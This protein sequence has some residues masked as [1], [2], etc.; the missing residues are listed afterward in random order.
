MLR[1]A[2]LLVA[3]FAYST[4]EAQLLSTVIQNA[5]IVTMSGSTLEK[6]T[7]ILKGDRIAAIGV[8]PD[9]PFLSRRIDAQGGTVT[10]GLI[11]VHS[12]L[13]MTSGSARSGSPTARAVDAFDRYAAEHLEE[14]LRNG[15]TTV[16]ISS[17]GAVGI[18]GTGAVVRLVPDTSGTLGQPMNDVSWLEIDLGSA[19]S[20]LARV[21]TFDSVRK[22]L[23]DA[24]QYRR[25][26]EIY[27]ED[28]EEYEEKLKERGARKKKADE[29]KKGKETASDK[30]K[31]SGTKKDA[32]PAKKPEAKDEL[33]KPSEPRRDRRKE[34]L[35][36]ALDRELP[37][38]IEAHRSE[39]IL[40][41]LD[42]QKE[43]SLDLTLVGATEAHLVA[44]EISSAEVSVVL[45][46]QLESELHTNGPLR[47]RS[48]ETGAA[49]ERAGVPWWVG[50]GARSSSAARFVLSN[51][52]IASAASGVE[53]PGA[54]ALALVTWRAARLLGVGDR[55]GRLA[56]NLKADLVLWSGDPLEPGSVVRK[57]F[58]DGRLAYDAEVAP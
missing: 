35:L 14:A 22:Q 25:S 24:R 55:I 33:K 56:P 54:H 21:A 15:V 50:S 28:L 37:V 58:V 20:A 47:R 57:V 18:H 13:G 3:W 36:R 32:P 27:E 42:L 40:N 41:A 4:V 46:N 16:Y 5:R 45:G 8:D 2:F 19:R 10:P 26:R 17:Q 43:F 44:E 1:F 52:R 39:D 30:G 9:V 7:I 48:L 12:S 49:L 11:D 31:N 29:E 6:G 23:R 53:N 38:R 34:V 51:A